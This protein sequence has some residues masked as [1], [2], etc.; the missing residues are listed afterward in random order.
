MIV[1]YRICK[2][3]HI[4]GNIEFGCDG[5]SAINRA[6]SYVSLISVDEPSYDILAA[7]RHLW[8]YSPIQ[9]KIRH[10]EGHQDDHCTFE[11]LD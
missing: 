10:A 7:I 2:Y 9:W 3:Y 6:F 5:L 4:N 1:I 8:A 11:S